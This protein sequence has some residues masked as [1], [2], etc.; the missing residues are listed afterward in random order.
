MLE[1]ASIATHCLGS[2]VLLKKK[3][4][5]ILILDERVG[6]GGNVQWFRMALIHG[7]WLL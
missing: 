3:A 5:P 2:H 7:D 1:K 6:S 4:T